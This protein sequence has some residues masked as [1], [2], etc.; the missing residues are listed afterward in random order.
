LLA[1][2]IEVEGAT[3][4]NGLLNIDLIR[5]EPAQSVR[6]V[7]IQRRAAKG[8]EK[9]QLYEAARDRKAATTRRGSL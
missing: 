9:R 2:S 8:G 5:P 3:L 7:E 1:E 6:T 4:D